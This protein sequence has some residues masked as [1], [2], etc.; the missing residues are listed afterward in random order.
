MR[1][2]MRRATF[3]TTAGITVALA[4]GLAATSCGTP[5]GT[6][7]ISGVVPRLPG[8]GSANTSEPTEQGRA[9]KPP[10]AEPASDPWA[11]RTDL[12]T[13]PAPQA[14]RAITLPPVERFTLPNGLPVIVLSKRDVPVID[15]QLMVRAGSTD[16][17]PAKMGL[18]QF[19][20]AMLPK[21]TRTRDARAIARTIETVGGALTV[22]PGF[23]ATLLSC[24]ALAEHQNTCLS[25]IADIASQPTFPADEMDRVRQEL[26]ASVRQRYDDAG[27]LAS[28]HFQNLLWGDE[29]VRGR[30]MSM[31]TID[32]I[33][34]KDLV[35]WHR[36]WFVPQNATL[37]L[38][39]DID[40]KGLRLRLGQ[41]FRTWPRGARVPQHA[42][43]PEPTLAGS[44]IRL[45]D[46]PGQTQTHIRIGHVGIAH[47]DPAFFDTVVFNHV[48]GGAGFT[49]RLMRVIRVEGGKAYGV[50]TQFDRSRRPGSFV[51]STF[52]RNEEAAATAELILNELMRMKK[53]GPSEDEV[54]EAVT[55]LAGQYAINFQSAS[56]IAGALLA[57]ELH[58]LGEK[59]VSNYPLSL[60]GVNAG[61]AARA[62]AANLH[63]EAVAVVLVG[64]AKAVEPQLQRRGW[65][66]DKVG[67]LD[68]I[69]A[70]ERAPAAAELV[71]PQAEAAA[72]TLLARALAAKGGEARLRGIRSMAIKASGTI[73]SGG[74]EIQA[75][76][77]RRFLPPDRLRLDLDLRI[78]GGSAQVVTVLDRKQAWSQQPNGVVDL[79]SEGV[80]ELEKQ[81]WRDQEFILLRAAEPG[82]KVAALGQQTRE[83]ATFEGLRITRADGL[84]V[85]L[86]L[87]PKTHLVRLVS[88]E[89]AP[90]RTTVE[91]MDDYRLV[92][93][94]QVAHRRVTRSPD[95]DLDV[96]VES[97]TFNGEIKAD[98]FTRPK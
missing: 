13:A 42:T 79:P 23:E 32:A 87:D 55:E 1:S 57:A 49:S 44:R 98:I 82:V 71:S 83:G 65:A 12:I 93:G 46:K 67:H 78:P 22:T 26:Q 60:A 63:P 95:A 4:L 10:A 75:G 66:Y 48:L 64:D 61:S 97:V 6:V 19:V 85:D 68:P 86:F 16:V 88:Y 92:D 20:S 50:G 8:D 33:Q 47:P 27:A 37:V 11:G 89:E 28:A 40:A 5:K 41:A 7:D 81:L 56:D 3:M 77:Q 9:R 74:Q 52:T 76:L 38:A 90:G 24:Q 45:V 94:L 18:S 69:A 29:H 91:R 58:G 35:D 54:R 80:A 72:K 36:T 51:A 84:S 2:P 15:I 53:E 31:R 59:Y 39:G 70:V 25:L 62:A 21:G 30:P 96:R 43:H 34:R 73:R 14:P 17:A